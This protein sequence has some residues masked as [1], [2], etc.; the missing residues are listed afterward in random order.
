MNIGLLSEI[1]VAK[2]SNAD[3]VGLCRTEFNFLIRDTLP[4]E[5]EQYEIYR[6]ILESFAPKPVILRTLDVG[7]DKP[8]PSYRMDELNPSL[9]CRGIRFTLEHPEIFMT[10]VAG[11]AAANA[12]LGNLQILL[13]MVSQVHEVKEARGL[14]ERA[15]R[16]LEEEGGQFAAPPVGVM[17]EVPSAVLNVVAFEK[18]VD[19][20]SVGTNDLTQYLLAVDRNNPNVVNLYDEADPSVR[21]ALDFVVKAARRRRIPSVSGEMGLSGG[22]YTTAWHGH[23]HAQHECS[24]RVAD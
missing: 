24:E 2:R 9:G 16:R 13:P 23:R 11:D 3:G 6:T 1:D 10:R 22:R 4:T 15:Q 7:G 21:R 17:I 5:D 8:L 14:L 18:Y 19:F 12:G 20:L